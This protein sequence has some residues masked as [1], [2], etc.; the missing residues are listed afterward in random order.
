VIRTFVRRGRKVEKE[1]FEYRKALPG[2]VTMAL[3]ES[4]WIHNHRG[5]NHRSARRYLAGFLNQIVRILMKQPGAHAVTDLSAVL[6]EVEGQVPG[7]AKPEQRLP[8]LALY[9]LY[10]E[11]IQPSGKRTGW[12]AFVEK[13]L[14]DFEVPAMESVVARLVT[15]R[16]VEWS[17]TELEQIRQDYLRNR[18]RKSGLRIHPV[19][20]TAVTLTIAE[21]HR[22]AGDRENLIQFIRYATEDLPGKPTLIELEAQVA[23]GAD[24]EV[25][26]R[27]L[28]LPPAEITAGP[29]ETSEGTGNAAPLAPEA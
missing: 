3:D 19:L 2:I 26:W 23:S 17:A 11:M 13:Y 24:V 15:G 10:N 22:L 8:L 9:L 12:E 16:E 29:A 18:Y 28:L 25:A 5:F 21:K 20:E 14:A 27:K 4:L 6:A 1:D 7:L